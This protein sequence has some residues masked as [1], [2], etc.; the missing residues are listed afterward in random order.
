MGLSQFHV[1]FIS[2]STALSL[3]FGCWAVSDYLQHDGGVGSLIMGLL[4]FAGM[5]ALVRYGFWFKAKRQ[6]LEGI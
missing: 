2:V 5:A 4:S 3:G 6:S 1:F